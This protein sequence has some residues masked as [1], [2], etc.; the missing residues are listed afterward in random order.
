MDDKEIGN[1]VVYTTMA[2]IFIS[3]IIFV[4]IYFVRKHKENNK[5]KEEFVY[6]SDI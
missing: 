2:I 4:I 3:C 1:I 5:V 6:V